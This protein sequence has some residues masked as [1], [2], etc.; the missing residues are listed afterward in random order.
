MGI[1][2]ENLTEK[3]LLSRLSEVVNHEVIHAL[4]N[5]GVFTDA[6]WRILSSIAGRTKYMANK[7][8]AIVQRK[9]TYLERAESMYGDQSQ[10][11]IVEEAIAEMYRDW[12]A[13]RLKL[14]GRPQGFMERIRKFFLSLI[15]AHKDEGFTSVNQIFSQISSGEIGSRSPAK[16]EASA[17]KSESRII[18]IN[19]P[20]FRRWFGNSKIVDSDGKPLVVYHGSRHDI[21]SFIPKY[22]DGLSFFTTNPEFANRWVYN[23]PET[24]AAQ[25]LVKEMRDYA[26]SVYEELIQSGFDENDFDGMSPIVD[27]KV[28]EKY[29]DKNPYAVIRA[30]DAQVYPVFLSIQNPFNAETDYHK[31]EQFLHTLPRMKGAL[32]SGYHKTGNWVIYENKDVIDELKRMGYDGIWLA[33]DVGGPQE[34]IAPFSSN[35]IKSVFNKGTWNPE[36]TRIS[37]SRI[38]APDTDEFR[39][40]FRKSHVIGD[41]GKARVMF[42]GTSKDKDFTSF[43]VGR[44]GGW[45]TADPKEA[46]QY[47]EENDS[48]GYKQE[49]WK[50]IKTNTASRVIPAFLR[51]ENPYTGELPESV[52]SGNYKKSQ[53]DWFD[54]LRAQG[55]DSWIPASK[56]GDLVVVLNDS[57][58]VKSAFN[59][60]TFSPS[61]KNMSYSRIGSE[62]FI[63]TNPPKTV[64]QKSS[65]LTNRKF[66]MIYSAALKAAEN[67]KQDKAPGKQMLGILQNS[68][69]VTDVELDWIGLPEW[70]ESQPVV[71]KQQ[72]IDMIKRDM[73]VITEVRFATSD[74][75]T[76][77]ESVYPEEEDY[78]VSAADRNAIK[79]ELMKLRRKLDDVYGEENPTDELTRGGYEDLSSR[80]Q[81]L[82][83][84]LENIENTAR[85]NAVDR[86]RSGLKGYEGEA[87]FEEYTSKSAT[88]NYRELLLIASGK[89]FSHNNRFYNR[90]HWDEGNVI[91]H[92]RYDEFSFIPPNSEFGKNLMDYEEH[93]RKVKEL[94]TLINQEAE[95]HPLAKDLFK[96]IVKRNDE[97]HRVATG[98]RGPIHA[99]DYIRQAYRDFAKMN[100]PETARELWPIQKM[101]AQREQLIE[102]A[103]QKPSISR[104]KVFFVQE[105]QS[106]WGQAGR[107]RGF[108]NAVDTSNQQGEDDPVPDMPWKQN[109]QELAFRRALAQAVALGHKH[110]AWATGDMNNHLFHKSALVDQL[111]Y[112]KKTKTLG[113]FRNGNLV[114]F[115]SIN[116][117]QLAKFLDDDMAA[118]LQDSTEDELGVIY[119]DQPTE[120]GGKGMRGF[121]DKMMREYANKFLKKYNTK[122]GIAEIEGDKIGDQPGNL[123]KVWHFE[124]P[125]QL[126]SNIRSNGVK[127]FSRIYS[128]PGLAGGQYKHGTNFKVG[129]LQQRMDA[130]EYTKVQRNIADFI[131]RAAKAA[132]LTDD[133]EAVSQSVK[134]FFTK[135]QDD[136]LSVGEM[137]DKLRKQG[138]HIDQDLDAYAYEQRSQR[139]TGPK[140]EKFD[141]TF[142]RPAFERLMSAKVTKAEGES[143]SKVSNYAK[144]LID[145]GANLNHAAGNAFLYALHAKERNQRISEMSNGSIQ[146][147]SGMSDA[148]A[149]SI[150]NWVKS[151]P[152]AKRDVFARLRA[153]VRQMIDQTNKVYVEGGLIPDYMS[154]DVELPDGTVKKFKAYEDYVPLSGFV[155]AEPEENAYS[156]SS[157]NRFGA[158]GKPNKSPVGRGSYAGD[159]IANV[160]LQN[161]AGIEKAERNKVGQAF[162]SLLEDKTIPTDDIAEVRES[163]PMK[164]VV[165]NGKIR[166]VP[167]RE[168]ND[169]DAPILAVRRDGKEYLI[170]FADERIAKAMKGSLSPQQATS[171]VRALHGVTRAY[172]SLLTT[173]NP[174]FAFSN[175]PRDIQT[176]LFNAQMYEMK[177][178]EKEI[179][180]NIGSAGKAVWKTVSG[181]GDG[182]TYWEKRYKQFYEG[183]AQ[184]S[185][186]Q[187]SSAFRQAGMIKNIIKDIE[188]ADAKGNAAA[189]KRLMVGAGRSIL[190]NIEAL[191]TATENATRLSF[192]DAVVRRLEAEGVSTENAIKRAAVAAGNLTTNF[193][194][195]GEYRSALNTF[196]VFYNAS[197]QG[198]TA[199]LSAIANSKRARKA[200]AGMVLM[201]FA[202]DMLNAL[203][204][205]DDDDDGVKDWDNIS[206]YTRSNNIIFPDINGDGT[207]VKIPMAYG[208]NVFF[209]A[210]RL[211]S[212]LTR[213]AYGQAGTMTAGEAASSLVGTAVGAL[214]P[215]GG[216]NFATFLAPTQLDLPVELL[217]NKDFRGNDIYKEQSPYERTQSRSDLYWSTTSPSAIKAT[218]FVNDVIGGGTDVI[219]G[220]ILGNRIDF[221]PDILEHVLG[222]LT[223]GAGQFVVNMTDFATSTAP[224]ALMGKWESDMVNKTPFLSKFATTVTEKDRSSDYYDKRDDVLLVRSEFMDAMKSGDR[225]RA[226]AVRQNYPEEVRVMEVINKIDLELS[227]LRKMRR[228]IN[229]NPRLSDDAKAARVSNIE[230]R[231]EQL[232]SQGNVI[233]SGV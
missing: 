138:F 34:T 139:L 4:K 19:T 167:T 81:G 69:E 162:L 104:Q 225:E 40:W 91:A 182:T 86:E 151:L 2:D 132:R 179:I 89:G 203:I 64:D 146:N 80:I 193:S 47:A 220:T 169:R 48:Q 8:G 210:G 194:K 147:G 171:V 36:D 119:F 11:V 61:N 164:R 183:G 127:M 186:N 59:R 204:S 198:S 188:L 233:M 50:V 14:S 221:Q 217:L 6:E 115:E 166:L 112:N 120:V 156:T 228:D 206:D 24:D 21:E 85:I 215:F 70:L 134:D 72:V 160:G 37:Y 199:I 173:Y 128:A 135:M 175:L 150:L 63:G 213:N 94:T 185:L 108:A 98:G 100:I 219:P 67:I 177:G 187:M 117:D 90:A 141:S 157:T 79:S 62:K 96:N 209:N 161:H 200:V 20:A 189:V 211:L 144:A 22:G 87:R 31:I 178:A 113:G 68:P 60:G 45:F 3:Q 1:Y 196:Y 155:D 74:A 76:D 174:T 102:S 35:Q 121:Y 58:Q 106:D 116:D 176:A 158:M 212:N 42:T 165:V 149:D 30:M 18:D 230:K 110:F 39:S 92:L 10:Q 227:R 123:M 125:E 222:F 88:K 51:A 99:P 216:D 137:Y 172:A 136:M 41:D 17:A 109:W 153:D 180:A 201:G 133:E 107:K 84:E 71:T 231:M 131:G 7:S 29:G 15:R 12:E 54:K 32:E 170:E 111:T 184:N 205:G 191:N 38:K 33:E 129:E 26:N 229:A 52:M 103:P 23:R 218:K 148:E 55:Y 75:G 73:P 28:K 223:G 44:H 82:E 49:G 114:L 140:K 154:E 202:L 43:N 124:I 13:G 181:K 232:I 65:N 143:L 159:I 126:S 208:L 25:A 77:Y 226:M 101:I 46:S 57:T 83:W 9:Y 130:I 66:S 224:D 152:S 192:F 95:R 78:E 197:L 214:N 27:E 93:D 53:S 105:F 16:T 56:N 118:Q 207:Y 190:G 195:G 142:F 145:K 5:K 97:A 122:V 168:F 163:H